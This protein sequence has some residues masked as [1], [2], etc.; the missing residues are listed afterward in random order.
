M[1]SQE[2]DELKRK[3]EAAKTECGWRVIEAEGEDYRVHR[4]YVTA[5]HP[6]FAGERAT[7]TPGQTDLAFGT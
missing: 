3:A 5:A 4:H 6:D 7:P 1:T 2:R